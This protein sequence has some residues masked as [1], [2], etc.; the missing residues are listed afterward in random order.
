MDLRGHDTGLQEGQPGGK[1]SQDCLSMGP[2]CLQASGVAGKTSVA[3]MGWDVT[4]SGKK[5]Q[6]TIAEATQ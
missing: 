6:M 1:A 3:L 2:S 5:G 4:H